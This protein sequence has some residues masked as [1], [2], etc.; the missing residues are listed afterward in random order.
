FD[1]N[2]GAG[3][4]EIHITTGTKA[5]GGRGDDTFVV[6]SDAG[7]GKPTH[8]IVITDYGTGKDVID[9]TRVSGLQLQGP[10]NDRLEIHQGGKTG[11]GWGN[12]PQG[13]Q[14]DLLIQL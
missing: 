6:R 3:N 10:K 12:S 13:T 2:G 7:T 11:E 14:K 8:Q 1:I 4:D 5:T 9:L